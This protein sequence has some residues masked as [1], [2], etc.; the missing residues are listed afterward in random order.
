MHCIPNACKH[1]PVAVS[2]GT[3]SPTA[4]VQQIAV[5]L[6]FHLC[7]STNVSFVF[8]S[9]NI[10]MQFLMVPIISLNVPLHQKIQELLHHEHCFVLL[11]LPFFETHLN[12]LHHVHIFLLYYC[13][14]YKSKKSKKKKLNLVSKLS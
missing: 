2:I 6:S 8:M 7:S 14:K 4:F 9:V 5:K 1:L 3:L 13:L 11:S 12:V 10:Y